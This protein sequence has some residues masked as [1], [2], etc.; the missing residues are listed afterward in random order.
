MIRVSKHILSNSNQG[1]IH[2]MDSLFCDYKNDLLIY[3]D[4]IIDGILPLKVNLSSSLLPT[5][6][7]KHSKY[8][9]EIYKQASSIIRSQI[10]KSD[11]KRFNKYKRIYS[12]YLK[13]KPNSNFLKLRFNELNLKNIL[14]TKYFTKPKLNNISINLTNEFFNIRNESILFNNYIKIILPYF[15]EKGTR[16]LQ[17]KLPFNNHKHSLKLKTEGFF[18]RNNI[19][20]KKVKN[21][22]YVSLIWE[23]PDECK[24]TFGNT[25]AYDMGYNKLLV[26][27][28]NEYIGHNMKSIY[29]KISRKKQGSN[30]FKRSLIHRDNEIN[31]LI[32]NINYGGINQII[33]EDLK[34]VKI[35]K[36]Y[37]NNKIQRWSY[38]KCIDK[39]NRICE[40]KGIN[41][42]KV[43]P[44]YTSQTCSRCGD[45]HKESRNGEKFKCIKCNHEIDADY[46]AAINIYNR[47][48]YSPS[49][50]KN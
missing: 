43:L 17:V 13:N 7:I 33:V 26:S 45:I 36:K 12:Y 16:A 38:T 32:N 24:K 27:S 18:L 34:S 44:N 2:L 25:I 46:N 8:K 15:N 21:Q 29:E 14:K 30:S 35:G 22:Y 48:V 1:K 39:F 3:I 10:K 6:N 9:R 42:V 23:K 5:E 37:F 49:N 4:Y 31:R 28:N 50:Q 19:Q 40:D 11:N 20:L 41:L 47:G